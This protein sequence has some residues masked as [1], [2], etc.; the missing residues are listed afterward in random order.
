M[1]YVQER[2]RSLQPGRFIEIGT[3]HGELA[4]VLL[5]PGWQ[6]I[7]YE[8]GESSAVAARARTAGKPFE[9][10]VADW[11]EAP[12]DEPADL[13]VSSMVIEHL[14]DDQ[15]AAYFERARTTL[16]PGGRVA[17]IV[18]AGPRYW[19][20]EDDVAGHQRRYTRDGLRRRLEQLGWRLEHAA[21]LTFP[22]SNLILPVSNLLV[23]RAEG[24]RVKLSEYD[25]TVLSG[26]RDVAGKTTFP[27]AAGVVLNPTVMRPLHAL[28]KRFSKTDRA[29]VLYAEATPAPR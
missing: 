2:L 7:G 28:Q 21:G 22:V 24:D 27:S 1:L 26:D 18:P 25:R 29:L 17:V 12:P 11:L 16:R 15:E 4:A 13:I 5:D 14:P 20:I 8:L 9:V 10:R 19:G 6:G 23:K 3:G